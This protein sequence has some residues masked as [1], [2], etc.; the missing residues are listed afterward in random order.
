M[1]KNSLIEKK[2]YRI[3][4]VYLAIGKYDVLWDEFYRSC[5]EYLFPDAVKHYFVFTD[6]ERLLALDLPNVSLSFR[7]DGGWAMNALAKYDCMLSVREQLKT[8]D[9]LFYI[10]ANYK[11]QEPIYC[12]EILATGIRT[13]IRMTGIL[14]VG[15]I[16]RMEKELVIIRHVFMVE[17]PLQC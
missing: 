3:A 12:N 14:G 9:F 5:E 2:P 15:H 1:T 11:I 8:F 17:G 6:S 13:L 16:S 10:N 7:G 4:I